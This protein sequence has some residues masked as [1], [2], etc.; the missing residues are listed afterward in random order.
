MMAV[1]TW[2]AISVTE[3]EAGMSKT[4]GAIFYFNKNKSELFINMIDE[5]FLPVFKLSQS[6]KIKLETCSAHT[7][8]ATYKTPFER[9]NNDLRINYK[10][11]NPSKALFNILIQAQNHYNGFQQIIR[12]EINRE[13]TEIANIIGLNRTISFD[14]DKI[15][16]Q[17]VGRIFLES[18]Y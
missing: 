1:G 4:R 13:M 8:F 9:V 11:D 6:D 7:F 16:A 2:A 5:L 15:Y 12:E 18:L 10:I 17:S 3:L 14:M